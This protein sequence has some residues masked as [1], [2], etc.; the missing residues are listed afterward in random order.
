MEYYAKAEPWKCGYCKKMAK[1]KAEY[2]PTCGQHWTSC[3]DRQFQLPSRQ[4]YWEGPTPQSSRRTPRQRSSSARSKG[5]GKGKA[6]EKGK[7][8][9]KEQRKDSVQQPS[10]FL[11]MP[12]P[13]VPVSAPFPAA[14]HLAMPEPT[15][16]PSELLSA[17]RRAFPDSQAIPQEIKDAIEKTENVVS[18]QLT[19][20]LHRATTSMGKAQKTLK[21]LMDAKERHRL[22]WLQHLAES[23]KSW[24]QQLENYDTKQSEFV[25]SIEK[26]K[27]DMEGAHV[28][29]QTLNAKAA[30]KAVPPSPDPIPVDTAKDMSHIRDPEERSLRKKLHGLLADCATK[31]DKKLKEKEMETVI[32][33]EDEQGAKREKRQRSKSPVVPEVQ[34][35]SPSGAQL[36]AAMQVVGSS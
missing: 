25:D 18:R 23:L 17:I 24:Q 22:Q 11:M 32:S 36:S 27:Q 1:A 9:G 12:S 35:V 31:M 33:S 3:Q 2:C 26:A 5:R 13:E 19:Q 30:G 21:E 28:L 10:P 4:D 34:V 16:A 6:K 20:D 15:S 8:K 14:S 7:D 29:I